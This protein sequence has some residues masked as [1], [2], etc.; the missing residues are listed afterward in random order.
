MHAKLRADAAF[1]SK[2]QHFSHESQLKLY[3]AGG[4]DGGVGGS[5]GDWV[6]VEVYGLG[7]STLHATR[8]MF[9]EHM[10]IYAIGSVCVCVR[11][12]G[13]K[14]LYIYGRIQFMFAFH[15]F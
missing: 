15:N 11:E 8:Q 3:A 14:D 10:H 13:E 7:E 5:G 2:C 12:T 6:G 1:I 9:A 4:G